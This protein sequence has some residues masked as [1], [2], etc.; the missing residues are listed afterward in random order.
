MPGVG[1]LGGVGQG[2]VPA[3]AQ[4]DFAGQTPG[5]ACLDA[6]E[7]QIPALDLG[8]QRCRVAARS[9]ALEGRIE[10]ALWGHRM[11]QGQLQRRSVRAA[12]QVDLNRAGGWIEGKP[13][14]QAE[15]PGQAVLGQ[16]AID[17]QTLFVIVVMDERYR[18]PGS[19]PDGDHA[20]Y[21]SRSGN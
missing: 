2:S 13:G 16:I 8:G 18:L 4:V 5:S 6:L 7:I 21:H 3:G 11:H 9:D 20:G 12:L 1:L 19:E 15:F 14:S 17:G 10:I